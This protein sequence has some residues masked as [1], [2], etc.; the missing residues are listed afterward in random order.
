MIFPPLIYFFFLFIFSFFLSSLFF[1]FIFFLFVLDI[2][3]FSFFLLLEGGCGLFCF[4]FFLSNF[5]FPME[6][7]VNPFQMHPPFFF[8]FNASF[9][10]LFFLIVILFF[11]SLSPRRMWSPSFHLMNFILIKFFCYFFLTICCVHCV[12]E[13]LFYIM[14]IRTLFWL[15]EFG[16]FLKCFH[17]CLYP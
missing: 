5:F 16:S 11:F 6:N 2:F 4:V 8:F 1:Y 9:F 12:C 13:I 10:F 17:I 7:V 15:L 14:I 3:F